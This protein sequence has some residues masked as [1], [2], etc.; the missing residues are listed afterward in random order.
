MTGGGYYFKSSIT[1]ENLWQNYFFEKY[2][3][4]LFWDFQELIIA[5]RSNYPKCFFFFFLKE[6]FS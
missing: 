2:Q 4:A 3:V 6:I 1:H 5:S